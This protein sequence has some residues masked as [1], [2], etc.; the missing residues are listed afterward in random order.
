VQF[1]FEFTQAFLRFDT[2][3]RP[4]K[5]GKLLLRGLRVL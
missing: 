1:G 3:Q 4:I 2:E 5:T